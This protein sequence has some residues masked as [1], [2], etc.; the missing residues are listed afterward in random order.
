MAT[1]KELH[2]LVGRAV[3]DAEFR[4]KMVADPAQ[5]AKEMGYEL[6]AEQLATLK[7][8]EGKGLAAVLDER[9][10]KSLGVPF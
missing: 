7:N 9:L 4:A 5:A 1:V 8:A 3:V 2:E 10:P 6:T